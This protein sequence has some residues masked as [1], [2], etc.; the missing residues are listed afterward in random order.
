MSSAPP[1][2]RSP[3]ADSAPLGESEDP[4]GP[5][6]LPGGPD[7]VLCLHGFT[8]TPF[9]LRPVLDALHAVGYRV[10]APRLVG[11]GTSPEALQHTR[12]EDWL[13]TARRAFDALAAEHARVHVVGMSMGSL[14]GIVVAHE[15]GARVGGLVCMATPLKLKL[16]DQLV[17]SVAQRLPLP[18]ALPFVPKTGGPDVSDPAVAAAMPSYD[19]IPLG[20]AASVLDGQRAATDRAPRLTVPV[21]IQH[22]RHDHV[23]P[24]HNAQRLRALLRTPRRRVI[25]YPRSWHILPLDVDTDQVV[26]DVVEFLKSV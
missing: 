14:V 12:W 10:H 11:H 4:G 7:A 9:E 2:D 16:T 25:I 23:A 5:V 1:I 13:A 8:S 21:L 18:E 22:G 20:A 3:P 26:T 15:R 6:D 19:R 24:V 17:L